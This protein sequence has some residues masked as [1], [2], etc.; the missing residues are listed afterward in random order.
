MDALLSEGNTSVMIEIPT[1][2]LD[3]YRCRR[4]ISRIAAKIKNSGSVFRPHFKTHVSREIGNWYRDYGVDRITVSSL[5]MAEYF[6]P[7]WDDILVA[8][9]VNIREIERVNTLAAKRRLHLVVESVEVIEFLKKNT[10]D[11]INIWIKIDAGYHRTGILW[12]E[13]ETIESVVNALGEN[14]QFEGFLAHSG[15]SYDADNTSNIM[16]IHDL[17]RVRMRTLKSIFPQAKLSLGDTPTCSI[18]EDFTGIDE[19]R[20]GNLVFYDLTQAH[21]GSC[22]LDD[23]AVAL[24]C[25]VVAVHEEQLTIYGGGVHF[26]KD[27]LNQPEPYYGLVVEGEGLSWNGALPGVSLRKISQEHGLITGPSEYMK[28][29]KP[30]DIVKILPVH[31]CMTADLATHYL[32]TENKVLSKYSRQLV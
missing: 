31:S 5:T 20:P 26:A 30:G 3:E 14:L 18:A 16:E 19:W 10:T 9:P 28:S 29:R 24:A 6:A 32:T 2:L 27:V 23:I 8:F 25:P 11:H 21:I 12:D 22:K 13:T 1:L 7:D 15:H 17:S 4:N